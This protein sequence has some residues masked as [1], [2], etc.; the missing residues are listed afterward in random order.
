MK[1][2]GSPPR[3][4][5]KVSGRLTGA[6]YARI[7]PAWAGKRTRSWRAYGCPWDH[8]RVGGEKWF[9]ALLFEPCEGS[10]PAW[11]GK[12]L[13]C[14]AAAVPIQD[15]PRIGGEKFGAYAK[16]W[17]EWGSPPRGRGKAGSPATGS[18]SPGITPAWAGKSS[19]AACS[20]P[21]RTDHPRMGGEKSF[22]ISSTYCATGSPPRRQGK[23]NWHCVRRPALRITPA[24]A[25]KRTRSW[26]AYGCPWD[27]PRVGGEKYAALLHD[28]ICVG[29]PPRWRGKACPDTW[30]QQ[31][32]GITPALAGKSCHIRFADCPPWDHPRV[33]GEKAAIFLAVCGPMGS[34]PRWRGKADPPASNRTAFR[35]TPALAGKSYRRVSSRYG[36]GDHP[37]V[38]GEKQLCRASAR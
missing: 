31:R 23:A 19:P 28:A 26:R 2:L 15:H 33:G 34:P 11:A 6:N 29:S 20:A 16:I 7:T 17:N 36:H 4:R 27:H 21:L 22:S 37:R 30:Q 18:V 3:R 24:Q 12:S 1:L 14:F 38:G 25:G 8:P 5:G 32:A 13:F 35:I 9:I 10:P